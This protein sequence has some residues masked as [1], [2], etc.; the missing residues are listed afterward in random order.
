[1]VQYLSLLPLGTAKRVV[2]YL[3]VTDFLVSVELLD[4]FIANMKCTLH[5]EKNTDIQ[6]KRNNCAESS[7]KI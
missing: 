3:T 1:M 4:F 7:L 5:E 2:G 6:L